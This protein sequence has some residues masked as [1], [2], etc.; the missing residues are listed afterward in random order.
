MNH[1]YTVSLPV[2]AYILRYV[3]TV[4]GKPIYFD[5]QSMLCQVIRAYLQNR[6]KSGLS[7]QQM[8]TAVST[9]DALLEI[10][11]PLNAKN[12]KVIGYYI[13]EDNVVLINRF[14]EQCFET[15]LQ[16]FIKEYTAKATSNRFRDYKGA[17]LAFAEHYNIVLD[18]DITYEGLKKIEF[19]S[20][21][22]KIAEN[23]FTF[24]PSLESRVP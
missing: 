14:L 21:E 17:Y 8:Q 5:S 1:H 11:V 19:R 12:L 7:R 6:N 4:E 9:R 20:R 13:S 2:K 10:K 3:H 22:K 23:F 18:E 24:V 15:A 16:K